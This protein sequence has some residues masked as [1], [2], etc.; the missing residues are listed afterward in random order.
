MHIAYSA[1][2]NTTRPIAADKITEE[3]LI[4]RFKAYQATCN[5]YTKEIA[6][7]Q[8]YI[9]GWLPACPNHG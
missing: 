9:P 7:I 3:Q 5:K 2:Q 1:L 6:A 4:I 8:K